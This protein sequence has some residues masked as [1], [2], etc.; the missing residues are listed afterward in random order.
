MKGIFTVVVVVILAGLGWWYLG[1]TAN[2]PTVG[3]PTINNDGSMVSDDNDTNAASADITLDEADMPENA[4]PAK[5]FAITA[6]NFKFSQKEI[7]VRKGDTVT[8]NFEATSGFHDWKIDEFSAA[9]D[10]VRPGT[11]TS[12]TFVADKAGSFEYY[13]SVGE[14]RAMGMVGKLVVE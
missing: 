12:V 2:A 11:K 14:H 13:C 3:T 6:E 1:D 5:S 4:V 8:I 9:T 7:R 10:Q